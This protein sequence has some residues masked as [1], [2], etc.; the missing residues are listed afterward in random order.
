MPIFY[1][2]NPEQGYLL[3]PSVREV[4]GEGH[5]CFFVHRT[6]EQLDLREFEQSYS[7]LGHPGYH[8]ALML[9]VWLY[10]YALGV[11]SSRRLEQ[12][13]RE[14][15][16]FRY[17]AA[18]AQPDYW[19][20]NEFRKRHGR[21]MNDVFTQV[22]ETARSVGMGKLGH[23]AID[24]TR[25]AANAAADSA[26]TME[27]LRGERAKIRKRIR[28]WQRQC[29]SEDPNE[30]GGTQVARESM[31]KLERRLKEIPGRIQ[32]LKKAGIK[33]LSR[34]DA[35][36]RFL[37]VRGRFVL[38]YTA[39]VAVSEDHLIVAQQMSTAA[40]DHDLL[41]PLVAAVGE[42]C[43]E[44]PQRISADSGFF[45]LETVK[46]LEQSGVDVYMPDSTLARELNTGRRARRGAA[47][48]VR[49]PVHRRLRAKLRSPG[50]RAVYARRKALVE[51]VFGVLKEQRGMRQFRRRGMAKV[52]V[53]FTLAAIAYNLTRLWTVRGK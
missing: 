16:A 10:A 53:E 27:K 19:A 33:R 11:T 2:Y 34:S 49:D 18:G 36:S 12:R 39:T 30:T 14:D 52:A 28:H 9:K 35:E 6:V 29:E 20:L 13:I 26:D 45:R 3:P 22:V 46:E 24:S 40:S 15:L 41:V 17:L 31:E 32:R 1:E 37:R 42:Q 5:L 51:P 25:I 38:G 44:R 4:L 48:P 43:G 50:G 23:A 8:P 21:A 7:E 47:A